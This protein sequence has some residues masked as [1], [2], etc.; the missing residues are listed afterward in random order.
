MPEPKREEMMARLTE[1]V[2]LGDGL[3]ASYDG[4]QIKLAANNGITDHDVV[5]LDPSV[6]SAFIAYKERLDNI[7]KEYAK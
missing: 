4:W 2:Y 6:I 1:R 3:F 7:M 5:F